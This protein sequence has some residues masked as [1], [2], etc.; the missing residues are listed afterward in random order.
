MQ[1]LEELRMGVEIARKVLREIKSSTESLVPVSLLLS[2]AN[3]DKEELDKLLNKG[4][5][6]LKERIAKLSRIALSYE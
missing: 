6:Q 5:P 2:L 1:P 4:D 3:A